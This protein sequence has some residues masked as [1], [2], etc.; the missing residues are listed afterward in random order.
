MSC[1]YS[2]VGRFSVFLVLPHI[3]ENSAEDY[4]IQSFDQ[5]TQMLLKTALKGKVFTLLLCWISA[6]YLC[7]KTF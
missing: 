4:R 7:Y 1:L 5:D 6:Q 2:T 3:M